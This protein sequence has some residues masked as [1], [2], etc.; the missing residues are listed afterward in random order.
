[1]LDLALSVT[2]MTL[3]DLSSVYYYDAMLITT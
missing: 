1:M 2:L 3:R